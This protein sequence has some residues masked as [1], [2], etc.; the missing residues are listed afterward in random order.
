MNE[1]LFNKWRSNLKL[2]KKLSHV[3]KK[4]VVNERMSGS[5]YLVVSWLS[6]RYN[7]RRHVL[8]SAADGISPLYLQDTKK[9]FILLF[10]KTE[11]VQ[12]F[13]VAF[14]TSRFLL[15]FIFWK[16]R[17]CLGLGISN[18]IM[19]YQKQCY[20]SNTSHDSIHHE[21]EGV[22]WDLARLKCERFLIDITM[23]ECEGEN[24]ME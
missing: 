5:L 22:W 10:V 3:I 21:C 19:I 2:L 13:T 4:N 9:V 18:Y 15:L 16:C 14:V 23:T 6:S 12:V 17:C 1:S 7:L 24:R 8:N 11:T 20:I